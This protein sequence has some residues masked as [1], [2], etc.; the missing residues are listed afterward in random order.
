MENSSVME[1]S[2]KDSLERIEKIVENITGASHVSEA[3]KEKVS[4]KMNATLLDVK[5]KL[6]GICIS[7]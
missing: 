7:C 3:W 1:S 5:G 6:P 2:V 4:E